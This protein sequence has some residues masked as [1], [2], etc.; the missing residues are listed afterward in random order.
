MTVSCKWF[1]RKGHYETECCDKH[2]E[3]K[4]KEFVRKPRANNKNVPKENPSD[5]SGVSREENENPKKRKAEVLFMQGITMIAEALVNGA[6]VE[7][8]IDTGATISAVAKSFVPE[9]AI[10]KEQSLA[11]A[12]GSGETLFTLGT[13]NLVVKFGDKMITQKAHVLETTAFQAVLGMDFLTGP[14][15]TGIITSPS[16]PKLVIDGELYPVKQNNQNCAA[17]RLFRIFNKES[18]TLK[19]DLRDSVLQE[20]QVPKNNIVIDVFANHYNHQEAE[21]FTTQISA[22]FYNWSELLKEGEILWANPPFS[23]LE[24]VVTKLALEPCRMVLV[25]PNWPSTCWTRI[26]EKLSL[27]HTTIPEGT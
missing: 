3:L 4:P 14:R 5:Q 24:K 6:P 25:T 26:L 23:Q 13:T 18:Y 15:C 16:P 10:C 21:Y 12:V 1:G 2:P 7:A 9:I 17:H 19:K 20:L 22:F 8:I 27:K 11:V